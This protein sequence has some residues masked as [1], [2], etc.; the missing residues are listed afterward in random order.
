M[1]NFQSAD[2][3]RRQLVQKYDSARFDLLIVIGLTI[4]NII[5]LFAGSDSMMLF[6]ASVPYFAIVFGILLD[7]LPLGVLVAAVVLVL[8]FVCWLLSKKHS[9][10]I[11]VALVLFSMD[12]LCL[13]GFYVLA[14]EI[15]GIMDL[16]IHFLALYYIV[17]GV[18]A[19]NKLKKMPEEVFEVEAEEEQEQLLPSTPL[20]RINENE[21]C[22]VLLEAHCGGHHVVYRRIK[23][24]NQLVI[25]HHIYDELKMLVE[26][27]HALS[28]VVDGHR[29]AVGMNQAN[30]SFISLDDQVVKTKLR[31]F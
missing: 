10:W 24:T 4:L 22:R 2:S 12:T 21:K 8:Y 30:Q 23:R 17:G 1:D 25:D 31:L 7:V 26:T 3:E 5:L 11:T 16:L 14:E 6:S 27:P 15:S 19:A 28:A 9:A 20:G 29:F 18:I 13:L